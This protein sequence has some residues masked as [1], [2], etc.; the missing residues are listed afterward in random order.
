LGQAPVRFIVREPLSKKDHEYFGFIG[1]EGA[2]YLTK[3]L[4][5]RVVAG[6]VLTKESPLIAPK[7]PQRQALLTKK[8]P[9]QFIRQVNVSDIIRKVMR[10]V[11]AMNGNPPNIWRSYFV[12]H[13]DMRPLN[14]DERDFC[15]NHHGDISA[16][17]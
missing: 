12:M 16:V 5:S 17:S 6:E 10:K 4:L 2:E 14:K 11:H 3:Y 8:H 15:E 1:S 7:Q 13:T 9:R